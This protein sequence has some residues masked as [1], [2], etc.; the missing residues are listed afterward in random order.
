MC[1]ACTSGPSEGQKRALGSLELEMWSSCELPGGHWEQ[2]PSLLPEQMLLR[3]EPFPPPLLKKERHTEQPGCPLTM[4]R[5]R[6]ILF[7]QKKSA[8]KISGL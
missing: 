6:G 4:N 1:T 3:I 8:I 2:S 7:S 5:Y